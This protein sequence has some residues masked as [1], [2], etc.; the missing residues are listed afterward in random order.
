MKLSPQ[1]KF[2]NKN[3]CEVRVRPDEGWRECATVEIA[4]HLY[5][6]AGAIMRQRRRRYEYGGTPMGSR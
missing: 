5:G 2:P 6:R 3:S 1:T 4:A